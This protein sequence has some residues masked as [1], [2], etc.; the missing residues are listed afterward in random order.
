MRTAFSEQR[1]LFTKRAHLAARKQLYGQWWPGRVTFDD[2]T[3]TAQDLEYAIDCQLSITIPDLRAPIKMSVQ[4]RFR[5][6]RFMRWGDVTI[7]EW[8][9]ASDLPSEIHKL[10]AQMFVYG[11]YDDRT[12]RIVAAV[13]VDVALLQF[14][15]SEGD[16]EYDRRR[17]IDQDFV[18]F[19]VTELRRI[20]AILRGH[21]PWPW[22][23]D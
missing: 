1:W 12:D 22:G 18:G 6:P 2:V 19:P 16:L 10:A 3:K 9:L 15:L 4:E 5:E 20:G 11:F 8:N 14:A 21:G 13:A 17:R 23:G 7:T